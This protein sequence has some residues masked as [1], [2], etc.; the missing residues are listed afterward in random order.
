MEPTREPLKLMCLHGPFDGA[1]L[2]VA[3]WH[4]EVT[5]KMRED[6]ATTYLYRVAQEDDGS[7]YL[8]FVGSVA[9]APA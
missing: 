9:A 1:E 2:V 5:V 6:S 7:R 8:A 3:P 4:R